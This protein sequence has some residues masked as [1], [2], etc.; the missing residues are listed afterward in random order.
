VRIVK[1]FV[2]HDGTTIPDAT[3]APALAKAIRDELPEA[4]HVTR[5]FPNWGRRTLL[6]FGDKIFYELNMLR[7]DS[8]FFHVFDFEFVHGSKDNPF[9]GIHSMLMTEST[10]RKY[11]G[12]ENPVGRII[13]TNINNNTVFKISG[14]IKDVPQNSHFSFDILIPFESGRDPNQD[15]GSYSFYTYVKLKP[16]TDHEA[17]EKKVVDLFKRHQPNNLNRH[18]TQELTDIHLKSHLKWELGENGNA[19]NLRIIAAIGIF[20][21]IIASINFVNLI[22]AQSAKR[23]KEVGVRKVTGAV[24]YSLIRQF[25]F[26]SFFIV[27]LSAIISIIITTLL[28]PFG[29]QI[30]GTDFTILFSESSCDLSFLRGVNRIIC[31]TLSSDLSV[32]F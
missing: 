24:R 4:E 31:R 16:L 26:E 2:N 8:S 14:I 6:E 20:V 25:L 1:D 3:T 12:N 11:F 30:V 21:L 10:A 19:D 13:K 32:V 29:E 5:F 7:V 15:W 23:A 28:L 9:N 22:T 27:V 18:Y 17:F